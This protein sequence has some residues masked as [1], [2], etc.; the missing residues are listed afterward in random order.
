M[1]EVVYATPVPGR[2]VAVVAVTC[3]AGAGT[4]PRTIY[5]FDTPPT[6]GT[7]QPLQTISDGLDRITGQITSDGPT[8]TLSGATYSA[9]A[10]RC[11]PDGTFTSRWTW[12]GH[13]YISTDP[14]RT[15]PSATTAP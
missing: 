9:G 5:V 8:L 4:P 12:A 15:T 6:V 2:T 14:Q 11:C 3:H 13:R 7:I 1:Y 10:P